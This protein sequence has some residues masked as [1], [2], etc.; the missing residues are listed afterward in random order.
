MLSEI[1]LGLIAFITGISLLIGIHEF[2]HYWTAKRL[3]VYVKRFSIGFGKPIYSKVGKSGTEF[4]ISMIPLGGYV[5]MLDHREGDVP[6]AMTHQ[7]FDRQST[8]KRLAIVAAGPLI[9]LLLALIAYGLVFLIGIEYTKPIIGQIAPKS[10]ASQAGLSTNDQIISIDGLPTPHWRRVSIAIALR[11]GEKTTML[12]NTTAPNKPNT[13]THTLNLANW[14]I[15]PHT[16]R[17]LESLGIKPYRPPMPP[18]ITQI[19]PNSPAQK[20]GLKPGDSITAIDSNPINDW[21]TLAEYISERPNQTIS[22]QILRQGQPKALSMHTSWALAPGWHIVGKVGIQGQ[23]PKWPDHTEVYD[24]QNLW[25]SAKSA[26]AET[27]L[28][29]RFNFIIIGKLITGKLSLATL[30]GPI[31]IFKVADQAFKQG[32]VIYLYFLG[33]LS[34]MLA[35]INLI[36]LPPLDGGQLAF[37]LI[38][39]IRRNPI[40]QPL[41]LLITRL[42]FILLIVLMF[43]ATVNDFIRMAS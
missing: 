35:C 2:G 31:A 42:G 36:P 28:F 32:L 7:A 25:Q 3:G 13:Q 41:Q 5:Q 40:S 23:T 22:A 14:S 17:P 33:T 43:Q 21:Y 8:P 19:Q 27:R 20:A 30:G 15:E 29:T 11:L 18:I 16:P 39:A 26:W 6:K 34:V 10:I 9:N 12:I 38:E 4:V 1:I 24:Q 37:L